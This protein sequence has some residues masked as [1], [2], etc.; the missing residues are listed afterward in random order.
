MI[1][2]LTKVLTQLAMPVN[3]ALVLVALGAVL[4]GLQRLRLGLGLLALGV[5][6]AVLWSLPVFSGWVRGTLEGRYP[7]VPVAAMPRAEAI[8]VLGGGMGGVVAPRLLPDL[9]SAADRV[10]HG[11]RLLLADKAPVV[12]V[13]GGGLAWRSEEPP[14][15]QSMLAFLRDLGVGRAHVLL[16]GR[17]ATTR[18]NAVEV[19]RLAGAR[20]FSR[21]LLVTSAL[22]MPRAA[23]AFRAVGLEV[24]PAPTD[25]EVVARRRVTIL[26]WLPDAQALA[27]SSRAFKEYLGFLVYWV[28][29]WA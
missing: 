23:A 16:E 25:Y 20:G 15:A 14:E 19:R 3:L 24:I 11:A 5:A 2:M 9:N 10:W 26:D 17:S 6:W 7:P 12:V 13:S 28:R 27:D 4:L 1:A 22:H 21:V 29:G 8:V 18:G